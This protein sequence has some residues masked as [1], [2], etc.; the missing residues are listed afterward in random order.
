MDHSGDHVAA[1]ALAI[2]QQAAEESNEMYWAQLSG[3][4]A[5]DPGTDREEPFDNES[6]MGAG[7]NII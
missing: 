4:R 3:G 5:I 1:Q 6:A 2:P 7:M